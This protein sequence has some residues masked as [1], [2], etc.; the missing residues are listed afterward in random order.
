MKKTLIFASI[1]T[2]LT[3]STIAHADTETC[4]KELKYLAN[5]AL[6]YTHGTCSG[7]A[8]LTADSSNSNGS[9]PFKYTVSHP[10][11][12]IVCPEEIDTITIKGCSK[13]HLSGLLVTGGKVSSATFS[14]NS[15]ISTAHDDGTGSR[16]SVKSDNW[17]Y[18]S[19]HTTQ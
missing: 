14:I 17:P 4:V 6:Q 18:V 2:L 12:S 11:Y 15:Q 7:S 8:Y 16:I 5:Q 10:S 3:A 13:H 1:A 19:F 9:F